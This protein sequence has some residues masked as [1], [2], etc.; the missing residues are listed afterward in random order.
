[1][2]CREHACVYRIGCKDCKERGI[3]KEY[4]GQTSRSIGERVDEHVKDVVNK[5]VDSPLGRHAEE[6]HGGESFQIE[7]SI[8]AKCYGRPSRRMITEAVMIE[9]I[10]EGRTMNSKSEWNYVELMKVGVR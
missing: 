6:S 9:E 5:N 10:E 8:K 3:H 7:A 4:V 1:M 2:D